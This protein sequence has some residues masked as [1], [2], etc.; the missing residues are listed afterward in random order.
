[1]EVRYRHFK[2]GFCDLTFSSYL[3]DLLISDSDIHSSLRYSYQA[4]SLSSPYRTLYILSCPQRYLNI[5]YLRPRCEPRPHYQPSCFIMSS[6]T[7]S[8]FQDEPT[9]KRPLPLGRSASASAVLMSTSSARGENALSSIRTVIVP[10]PEKEN[11]HPI[12]GL[13]VGST[14]ASKKRKASESSSVLATKLLAKTSDSGVC[15][16]KRSE[17]KRSSSLSVKT[18]TKREPVKEPVKK[19]PEARKAAAGG[20]GSSAQKVL[21]LSRRPPKTLEP[22]SEE[23]DDQAPAIQAS[24]DEAKNITQAVID[25]RCYELTVSPLAD[26]TD[27]YVQSSEA[28]ILSP[29][30]VEEV[31]DEDLP[32]YRTVKEE[33]GFETQIRDYFSSEGSRSGSI[34]SFPSSSSVSTSF[35][36][37]VDAFQLHSSNFSNFE[38][39]QDVPSTP[40]KLKRSATLPSIPTQF[41]GISAPG[42]FPMLST[43]E[44]K[45]LYATFTFTTPKSSPGRSR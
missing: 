40:K 30:K 23:T 1:M 17:L 18:K 7:F 38:K 32:E 6:R 24:K 42:D 11:L 12:T 44:R 28:L 10:I 16:A 36:D 43:P 14:S 26:V 15:K 31:K 8:V 39:D 25:A 21:S 13:G 45:E 5:S 4:S 3:H 29:K 20:D 9:V 34:S 41:K 19:G 35:F 33:S 2:R 37:S 22:V 27:A